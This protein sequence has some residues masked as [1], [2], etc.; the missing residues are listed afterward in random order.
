M[1]TTLRAIIIDPYEQ[2]V[3]EGEH[4]AGDK[5]QDYYD[6]IG[7]S[8]RAITVVRLPSHSGRQ[9]MLVLDDE[10]LYVPGQRFFQLVGYQQPL[11]GRAILLGV[12][13]EGAS[14]SATAP[15]ALVRAN[16]SWPEIE[17]A[18]TESDPPREEENYRGLGKFVVLAS[19]ATFRPRSH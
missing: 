3:T 4:P 15:V 12:T 10:G 5:P 13:E 16:V 14:A 2:T 8:C 9:H 1:L 6:A 17:F 18:G 11:A 19:R 7:H